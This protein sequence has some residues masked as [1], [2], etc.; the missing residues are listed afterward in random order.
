MAKW[1]NELTFS[2]FGIEMQIDLWITCMNFLAIDELEE[3]KLEVVYVFLCH[4]Y[5]YD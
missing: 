2:W 5:W 1:D 3:M 4:Y